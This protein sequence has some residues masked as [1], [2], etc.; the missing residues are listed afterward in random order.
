[1]KSLFFIS[2]C[3]LLGV[4]A[5]AGDFAQELC[6]PESKESKLVSAWK[7]K[8][9]KYCSQVTCKIA[10]RDLQ[11]EKCFYQK[12]HENEVTITYDDSYRG[13]ESAGYEGKAEF[14]QLNENDSCFDACRP[15]KKKILGLKLKDEVGLNRESCRQC[16]EARDHKKYDESIH[17]KEIGKRLYPSEKC[18]QLCKDPKGPI[19]LDR[20]PSVECQQCVGLNGFTAEAFEYMLVK[21]GNCFEIDKENAKRKV[22]NHFCAPH[23]GIILT[24]YKSGSP[25]TLSTIFMKKKPI[26]QELDDK[27]DGALYIKGVDSSNCET[28]AMDN[29]DR[30]HVPDKTSNGNSKQPSKGSATKQ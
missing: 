13:P 6:G 5:L 24:Y 25:Y 19:V 10:N 16:F 14:V 27:T 9:G 11:R 3:F 22:P 23:D 20:K 29:S 12:E 1:M 2:F 30:N 26:C 8:D 15:M 17:Y 28:A 18:Y 21:D 7:K 4:N